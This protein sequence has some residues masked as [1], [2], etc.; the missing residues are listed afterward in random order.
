MGNFDIEPMA[1]FEYIND[2]W[3]FERSMMSKAEISAW[4]ELGFKNMLSKL[5]EEELKQ[6]YKSFQQLIELSEGNTNEV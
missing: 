3:D 4:A 6:R 1:Q 5:T 2:L